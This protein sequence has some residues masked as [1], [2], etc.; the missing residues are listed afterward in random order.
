MK[1]SIII[2]NILLFY[3]YS[4]SI[5]FSKRFMACAWDFKMVQMQ[6]PLEISTVIF[7]KLTGMYLSY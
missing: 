3:P 7:K 5:N 2:A 4:T 6:M 1:G